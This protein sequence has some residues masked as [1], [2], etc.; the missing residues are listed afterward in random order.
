M[1]GRRAAS[2]G[3][4]LSRL[5]GAAVVSAVPVLLLYPLAVADAQKPTAPAAKPAASGRPAG[6]SDRYD[7]E[8]I[9]AISQSMDHVVKGNEKYLAKDYQG[10]L[11]FYKK[12]LA[13]N[14][15]LA[16]AHYTS[17]EAYL[18]LNNFPEA[19]AAFKAADDSATAKEPLVKSHVLFSIADCYERQKKWDDARKAWAAYAEHA[20]KIGGTEAG[21][22]PQ[23]AAA[24]MKAI[25]DWIALDKKYEIV[26][27][28][29]AAEKNDG[30]VAGGDAGKPGAPPAKK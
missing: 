5:V 19:E 24:R 7:P 17:G 2:G 30:G 16:I 4:R 26:R 27:Q 18:A 3:T 11:D 13:L 29:I 20:A 22:F 6:S 12:A 14:P 28:R 25:D 1:S 8:N 21:A 15:R 10:A 23:S 9:T